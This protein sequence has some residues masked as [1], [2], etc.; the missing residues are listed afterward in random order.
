M[1]DADE[2]KKKAVMNKICIKCHKAKKKEGLK[3][4]PTC[5]QKMPYQKIKGKSDA[6]IRPYGKPP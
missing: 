3:T 2:M 6:G 4:G 1:K 5:L